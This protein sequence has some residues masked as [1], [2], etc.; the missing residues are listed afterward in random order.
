MLVMS[1]MVAP[2]RMKDYGTFEALRGVPMPR[3]WLIPR[4]HVDSGR[5]SAAIDRLR[6]H[7]IQVQ[8]VVG[9]AQVDM[10]DTNVRIGLGFVH[11]ASFMEWPSRGPK[12]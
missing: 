12:P 2:V 8:R 11:Q 7:G 3:G 1:E 4:P 6:W 10:S 9:D 5:Y